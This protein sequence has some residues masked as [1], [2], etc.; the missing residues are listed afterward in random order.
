MSRSSSAMAAPET[1][2]VA[3]VSGF[4]LETG[5]LATSTAPDDNNI[6]CVGTNPDDM[7][8]A[9]NHI[10]ANNGGQVVV[11]GG[12]II[13]FLQLPIGGIV[14]D[15]DRRKWRG[16]R[17]SSTMRRGRSAANCHGRSCTCSCCRS[18]PF[19]TM[20]SPISGYRLR[21]SE[22]RRSGPGAV[23]NKGGRQC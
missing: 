9:I 4:G 23:R 6:V 7:A 11:D 12:R 1:V 13:A 10:I 16:R 5:A 17:R 20:R 3:F 15:I 19:R 21:R 2:P 18:P 22:G 14:S 8:V